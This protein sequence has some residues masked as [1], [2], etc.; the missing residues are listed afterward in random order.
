[1]SNQ[2]KQIGSIQTQTILELGLFGELCRAVT[3]YVLKRNATERYLLPS[4]PYST[5]AKSSLKAK[6]YNKISSVIEKDAKKLTC[7]ALSPT[8]LSLFIISGKICNKF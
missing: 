4:K 2:L 5:I 3:I 1:M 7:W 8:I 6:E